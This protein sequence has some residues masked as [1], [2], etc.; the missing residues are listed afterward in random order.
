MVSVGFCQD[1]LSFEEFQ[2]KR[3]WSPEIVQAIEL[4]PLEHSGKYIPR[5]LASVAT[6]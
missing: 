3:A 2:M 6:K 1:L 5:G 4:L